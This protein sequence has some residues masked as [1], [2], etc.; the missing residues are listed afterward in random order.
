M[1]ATKKFAPSLLAEIGSIVTTWAYI[2]QEIILQAS[3]LA[4]QATRGRPIE[5]LRLDFTSLRQKWYRLWRRHQTDKVFNKEIQPLNMKLAVA[6]TQRAYVVHGK[7]SV[8]GPGRYHLDWWE[9]KDSLE[10]YSIDYTLKELRAH[11][12]HLLKLLADIYRIG[13]GS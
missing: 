4:S 13:R 2:E 6:S 3:A 9:Q 8:T 7:W 5:P 10:R 12:K 11:S 1:A